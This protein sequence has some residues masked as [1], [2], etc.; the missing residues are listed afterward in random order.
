MKGLSTIVGT[1]VVVF[2]GYQIFTAHQHGGVE[3][4]WQMIDQFMYR[5][6]NFVDNLLGSVKR[7]E[8]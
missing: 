4:V 3:G 5:L 1:A 6:V 7:S 8:G 2:I